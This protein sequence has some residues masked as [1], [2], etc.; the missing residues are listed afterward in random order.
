MKLKTVEINGKQYAE[1]DTAG[2]PVYV[3]DDGKEIGFD[4]PLAIK[5]LQ[6]L[7]ARQKIIAWLKKLQRK[8]WL[9]LPLSKTRRR[10]SRHWKCCQKS[11]RKS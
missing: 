11:T 6:S 1:I 4:A 10:R 5:K 9:S 8:N 3:H 2:L 7:M